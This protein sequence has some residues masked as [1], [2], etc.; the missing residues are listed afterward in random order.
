V[1]VF[2]RLLEFILLLREQGY[3]HSN[4]KPEN[5]TLVQVDS[6]RYIAQVINFEQMTKNQL[7]IK[8]YTPDY[9]LNPNR[10]YSEANEI[11]FSN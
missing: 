7:E 8:E 6:S 10:T 2:W 1:H 9:F 11:V 4:I 3:C 5:I